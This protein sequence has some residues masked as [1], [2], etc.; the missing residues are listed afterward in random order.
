MAAYLED[1]PYIHMDRLRKTMINFSQNSL[2]PGKG[3][4]RIHPE[5]MSTALALHRYVLYFAYIEMWLC[6]DTVKSQLFA[7]I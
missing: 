5:Y 7:F 1:Y 4:K 2:Y 3:L 6:R